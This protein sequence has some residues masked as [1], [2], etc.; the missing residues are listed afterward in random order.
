MTNV[1]LVIGTDD[2]SAILSAMCD[3][4]RDAAL[5]AMATEM[6]RQLGSR[7]IKKKNLNYV[8]D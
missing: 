6:K 4:D 3:V 5:A 7:K 2:Y 8:V 1:R